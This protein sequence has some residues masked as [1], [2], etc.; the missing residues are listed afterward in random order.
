MTIP[1][2]WKLLKV[3]IQD[4]Q[5]S[6]ERFV[7]KLNKK[8][9]ASEYKYYFEE[10]IYLQ[11]IIFELQK[12][13]LICH[14]GRKRFP[15]FSNLRKFNFSR[16]KLY[17][18]RWLDINIQLHWHFG[19]TNSYFWLFNILL[20]KFDTSSKKEMIKTKTL[21]WKITKKCQKLHLPEFIFRNHMSHE[22]DAILRKSTSDERKWGETLG[23]YL[24]F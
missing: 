13:D 10:G 7:Q 20:R 16:S 4:P 5:W 2:K 1:W 15:V 17:Q 3:F 21:W 19:I 24:K 9:N 11:L 14:P 12:T 6:F 18:F 23:A 22:N 8:M